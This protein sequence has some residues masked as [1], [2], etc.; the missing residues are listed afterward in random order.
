[1]KL[2]Q[3]ELSAAGVFRCCFENFSSSFNPPM[4]E[5]EDGEPP[6]HDPDVQVGEKL[7]CP[8]CKDHL[9]LQEDFV[10]RF[11]P[12][13]SLFHATMTNEALNVINNANTL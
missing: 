1:M 9:V 4:P 12:S 7:T 10:W 5:N 11:E 2:S 13:Q 8:N 3:T 6:M